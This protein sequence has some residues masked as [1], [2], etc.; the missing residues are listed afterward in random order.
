[1]ILRRTARCQRYSQKYVRRTLRVY[2]SYFQRELF[3]LINESLVLVLVF[4]RHPRVGIVLGFRFVVRIPDDF[5]H[6][7][8]ARFRLV[9]PAWGRTAGRSSTPQKSVST[10]D[11]REYRSVRINSAGKCVRQPRRSIVSRFPI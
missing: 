7:E 10:V 1:M 9:S 5:D 6:L 2:L 8:H 3:V 4:L 11:D